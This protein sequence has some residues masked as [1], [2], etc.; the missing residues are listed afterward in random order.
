[1]SD[2]KKSFTLTPEMRSGLTAICEEYG[3]TEHAYIKKT[4]K[5]SIEKDLTAIDLGGYVGPTMADLYELIESKF[6]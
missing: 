2:F 6:P 4:I 3:I 1:M 5:D